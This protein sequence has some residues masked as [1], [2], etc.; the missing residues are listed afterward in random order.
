MKMT[1]LEHRHHALALPILI[2]RARERLVSR[3]RAVIAESGL[4]EQQ[5]RILSVLDHMGPMEAS[6]LA[7]ACS[8]LLP[9]QSRIVQTLEEGGMI[10]RG[11]HG[12]DRRRQMLEITD[13]GRAVVL[14]HAAAMADLSAEIESQ[15][16]LEDLAR[17]LELLET[18]ERL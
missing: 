13:A 7:Q 16:G 2:L 11:R 8:L 9:S 1:A 3:I 12:T 10:R 14:A 15:L 4:T 18:L 6:H 5:W 17:L